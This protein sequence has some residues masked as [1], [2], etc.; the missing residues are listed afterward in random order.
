[1][2]KQLIIDTEVQVSDTTMLNIELL[3]KDMQPDIKK[4]LHAIA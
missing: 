3:N 4:S 2:L 1:V